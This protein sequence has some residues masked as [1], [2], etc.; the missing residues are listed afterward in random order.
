MVTKY[1]WIEKQLP[2]AEITDKD[3]LY[4]TAKNYLQSGQFDEMTIEVKALDL[5][6][7]GV[8]VDAI[9]ML[10]QVRVISAPHGLDKLFPVT[11][12]EIPLDRPSDM[13]FTLG[14]ATEQSLTNVNN[15]INKDLLAKVTAIPSQTL[16]SAQRNAASLIA[17]ATNGFITFI[18]NEDGTPKEMVI[19]NTKD[20]TQCTN[21]WIWNVNGL[22]HADHY[23]IVEGDTVNIGLTMDGSIVADRITTGIL[24]SIIIRGCQIVVGGMDNA[25]GTVLVKSGDSS[26]FCVELRN[27]GV[28]FGYLNQNGTIDYF[29]KIQDDKVY[30]VSPG[31][32][33]RG[34]V[35]D[36]KVL[37][38]D[39]DDIWTSTKSS[40][41]GGGNDAMGGF[42]GTL[43]AFGD[44]SAS[45]IVDLHFRHGILMTG[46]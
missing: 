7:L 14:T 25:D 32:Y 8:N 39:V 4:K 35:V 21:C 38:L 5:T 40:Y 23:P 20:P 11:K 26:G 16:T 19:S 6:L 18:N 44:S 9:K 10:D 15:D 27:G 17:T 12:L 3:E 46:A 24:A 2:L 31:N 30:E 29:G 41:S 13:T 28:Y 43:Y 34:L 37:A 22:G 42:T 1:G 36:T 33:V 45:S